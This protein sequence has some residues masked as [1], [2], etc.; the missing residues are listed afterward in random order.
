MIALKVMLS[1]TEKERDKLKGANAGLSREIEEQCLQS[2]TVLEQSEKRFQQLQAEVNDVREEFKRAEE[3]FTVVRNKLKDTNADLCRKMEEQSVQSKTALEESERRS[4]QFKQEVNTLKVAL[5]ETEK[6]RDALRGAKAAVCMKLEEQSFRSRTALEESERRSGQHLHEVKAKLR[7]TEED[8]I[9]QRGIWEGTNAVLSRKL[10]EQCLQSKTAQ[11]ELQRR[12]Q[13]LQ[14]E[15]NDLKAHLREREE[16]LKKQ[17]D[18]LEGTNTDSSTNKFIPGDEGQDRQTGCKEVSE[19]IIIAKLFE[20]FQEDFLDQTRAQEI[21]VRLYNQG[22]VS[23]AKRKEIDDAADDYTANS[24]L[25]NHMKTQATYHM[26][27]R[28][29]KVMVSMESY[30]QMSSLGHKMLQH[31]HGQDRNSSSDPEANSTCRNRELELK[32]R[33]L[34]VEIENLRHENEQLKVQQT[35]H[36]SENGEELEILPDDNDQPAPAYRQKQ[37]SPD[38]RQ[39]QDTSHTAIIPIAVHHAP[40]LRRVY[41]ESVWTEFVFNHSYLEGHLLDEYLTFLSISVQ[42]LCTRTA[43][44][45]DPWMDVNGAIIPTGMS[46]V[47]DYSKLSRIFSAP[48]CPRAARARSVHCISGIVN[49]PFFAIWKMSAIIGEFDQPTFLDILSG[50][51]LKEH[52]LYAQR[53]GHTP[54]GQLSLALNG[55]SHSR[56][57]EYSIS[58]ILNLIRSNNNDAPLKIT[59][60][61]TMEF[62]GCTVD[63]VLHRAAYATAFQGIRAVMKLIEKPN[64]S[65]QCLVHVELSSQHDN[66]AITKHIQMQCLWEVLRQCAVLFPHDEIGRQFARF[67]FSGLLQSTALTSPLSL[68]LCGSYSPSSFPC[69]VVTAPAHT[70]TTCSYSSLHGLN[71]CFLKVLLEEQEESS[72]DL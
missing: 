6:E 26:A 56:G 19:R 48:C 55:P 17:R 59:V 50:H 8:L 70:I 24:V 11:E 43:G 46:S 35:K 66:L 51:C 15:L 61:L 53:T 4:E 21:V 33:Q 44:S 22:V 12:F 29:F 40:V 45:L 18:A 69:T 54:S 72:V 49:S 38:R 13:Q 23:Q 64:N 67:I 37:K 60:F 47:A 68:G 30:G 14:E 65:D 10:K 42:V 28:L 39:L 57:V 27:E 32:L 3:E 58:M 16:E 25:Y 5:R 71:T 7:D 34:E 1:E 2:E 31:L 9:R 62:S 63:E 52:S 41:V 20:E 36:L